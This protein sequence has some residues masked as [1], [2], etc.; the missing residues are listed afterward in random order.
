[1]IQYALLPTL[2]LLA[3]LAPKAQD[4]KKPA[5]AKTVEVG[6]V[7]PSFR[8]NDHKG[9]LRKVGGAAKT[10]WTVLVFYPMALTPG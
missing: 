2:L 4:E 7:A 6:A 10:D 9:A 1:M 3:P 5:P 8:L